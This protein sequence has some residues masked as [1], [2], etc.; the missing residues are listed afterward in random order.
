MDEQAETT[1]GKETDEVPKEVTR[2]QFLQIAGAALLALGVRPFLKYLWDDQTQLGDQSSPTQ[3]KD[4]SSPT[5]PEDQLSPTQPELQT[6]PTQQPDLSKANEAAELPENKELLQ[7]IKEI[8]R[9]MNLPNPY[10]IDYLITL[11]AEYKPP[12]PTPTEITLS[13][14]PG[15][16]PRSYEGVLQTLS[17]F[18]GKELYKFVHKIEYPNN[19]LESGAGYFSVMANPSA[20]YASIVHEAV[21]L[22]DLTDS[23]AFSLRDVLRLQLLKA[24]ILEKIGPSPKVGKATMAEFYIEIGKVVASANWGWEGGKEI[25]MQIEKITGINLIPDLPNKELKIVGEKAIELYQ[26]QGDSP[27]KEQFGSKVVGPAI[28]MGLIEQIPAMFV[29]ALSKNPD[30]TDLDYIRAYFPI[31]YQLLTDE[32]L[33]E[34]VAKYLSIV[35]GED[36]S[37]E[38]LV[39]EISNPEKAP[40]PK[41]KVGT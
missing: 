20:P 34:T 37:Y 25:R 12:P 39:A 19:F 10:P 24:K 23:G 36:V 1:T 14:P 33:K 31:V 30:Q 27:E 17:A 2:Q 26:L 11:C 16:D 13:I 32:Y 18:F 6:Q 28:R 38:Q 5:Q 35:R 21:H 4:Q 7:Q 29:E 3:P 15:V 41:Y 22:V 8:Y 9:K 40:I